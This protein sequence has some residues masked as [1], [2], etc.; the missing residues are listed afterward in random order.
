MD[1]HKKTLDQMKMVMRCTGLRTPSREGAGFRPKPMVSAGRRPKRWNIL[2]DYAHFGPRDCACCL[3]C[4]SEFIEAYFRNYQCKLGN[5][6]EKRGMPRPSP[7]F[8]C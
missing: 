8:G 5:M 2:K 4:S 3:N 1:R 6:V 7:C